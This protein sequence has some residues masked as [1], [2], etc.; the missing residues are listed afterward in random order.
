MKMWCSILVMAFCGGCAWKKEQPVQSTA[1]QAGSPAYLSEKI[2]FAF[3][4]TNTS[5]LDKG[6]YLAVLDISLDKPSERFDALAASL[7][8]SRSAARELAAKYWFATHGLLAE[9]RLDVSGLF[10][11]GRDIEGF[12]SRNDWVW[13]VRVWHDG[14]ALD[15]VIW[16]NAHSQKIYVLGSKQ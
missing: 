9:E 1:R 14:L 10:R 13:E 12:A 7:V 5:F 6:N 3:S 2:G 16:I 11:I 4:P 8:P 15:G